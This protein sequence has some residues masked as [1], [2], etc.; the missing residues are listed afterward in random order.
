M[1]RDGRKPEKQQFNVYLAPDLIARTKHRA[2]DESLSL[3][4]LVAKILS[5][6]LTR[7]EHDH[8]STEQSQTAA[9]GPR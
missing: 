8:D 3:S 4:D 6:Y 2:I 1:E 7:S 5:E 9:P